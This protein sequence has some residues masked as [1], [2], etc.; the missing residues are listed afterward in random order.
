M[1]VFQAI[2]EQKRKNLER[3]QIMKVEIADEVLKNNELKE[4]FLDK[5]KAIYSQTTK[6]YSK[7]HFV[8]T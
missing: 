3:I 2:K 8:K 4:D 6:G 5:N 7:T 1:K